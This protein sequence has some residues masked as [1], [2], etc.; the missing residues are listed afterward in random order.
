M[1]GCV[2]AALCG[3]VFT[4]TL[5]LWAWGNRKRFR[6]LLGMT[7][8]FI[9]CVYIA[10]TIFT[11]TKLGT[12]YPSYFA[13]NEI[14]LWIGAIAT[15]LFAI[16]NDWKNGTKTFQSSWLI[17]GCYWSISMFLAPL[18]W[19]FIAQLSVPFFI[20]AIIWARIE[21]RQRLKIEAEED[22]RPYQYH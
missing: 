7:L 17:V 22:S 4:L 1:G 18:G 2:I 6:A 12:H 20:W 3:S 9:V 15:L 8:L 10:N 11:Q 13:A 16:A 14:S 19:V 5:R 21:Y